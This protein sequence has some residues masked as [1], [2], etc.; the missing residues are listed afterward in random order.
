LIFVRGFSVFFG[1]EIIYG[2]KYYSSP[3][4]F[5]GIKEYNDR[6][7]PLVGWMELVMWV[8]IILEFI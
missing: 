4:P 1:A 2:L 8:L 5:I 7:Q 3:S 6:H